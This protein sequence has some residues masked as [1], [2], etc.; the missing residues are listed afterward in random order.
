MT[1]FGWLTGVRAEPG[2]SPGVSPCRKFLVC[3][4]LVGHGDGRMERCEKNDSP[5]LCLSPSFSGLEK[6][7]IT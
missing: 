2:R 7:E 4:P 5:T 3:R 1:F 6:R